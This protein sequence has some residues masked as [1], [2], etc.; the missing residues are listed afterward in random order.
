MRAPLEGL[1]WGPKL[2][3]GIVSR[4]AEEKK[5]PNLKA[6]AQDITLRWTCAPPPAG[7]DMHSGVQHSQAREVGKKNASRC[8]PYVSCVGCYSPFLSLRGGLG[9]PDYRLP[10]GVLKTLQKLLLH[11]ICRREEL[12][13]TAN[14]KKLLL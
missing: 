14:F 10:G 1:T 5:T 7:F 12:E 9:L 6:L 4:D 2:R 3:S 11:S 13:K 8:R